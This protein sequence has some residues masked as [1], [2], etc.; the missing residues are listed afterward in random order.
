MRTKLTPEEQ[1]RAELRK[2]GIW[3]GVPKKKQA[4]TPGAAGKAEAEKRFGK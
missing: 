1:H 4:T 2:Q 3:P